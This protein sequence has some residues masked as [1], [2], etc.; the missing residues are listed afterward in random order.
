MK[1]RILSVFLVFL[2]VSMTPIFA[3]NAEMVQN[4]GNQNMGAE[5]DVEPDLVVASN[6][7]S[8]NEGFSNN[9]T[10]V[11]VNDTDT[12]YVDGSVG[13]DNNTGTKEKP[14]K[15]IKKALEVVKEN[16]K[17][18]IASGVYSEGSLKNSKSITLL[19]ENRDQ[20][21][22]SST[23]FNNF[24]KSVKIMDLKFTQGNMELGGAINNN[25]TLELENCLFEDNHASQGGA[26]Y[27]TGTITI[28]KC[29]FTGNGADK[30]DSSYG[31][32][33][34]NG[35]TGSCTITGSSFQNNQA[36]GDGGAI[37]NN[38]KAK[39]VVSDTQFSGNR[40]NSAGAIYSSLNCTLKNCNFENNIAD[41]IG[42]G[43]ISTGTLDIDDNIFT[44]NK[45]NE[46]EGG[47][48]FCSGTTTISNT[49][50]SKNHA[51]KGILTNYG[52]LSINGSQ[53]INNTAFYG[54]GIA[55]IRGSLSVFN[56]EF[57]GNKADNAGG[58]IVNYESSTADVGN[59]KFLNNYGY[60]GGAI[61]NAGPCTIKN[62][63]FTGNSASEAGAI[64]NA[65]QGTLTVVNAE[66]GNNSF[67]SNWAQND[68]GAICN[69]GHGIL[70]GNNFTYNEI[71]K[72]DGFGGAI[73]NT[74][75]LYLED[76]NYFFHNAINCIGGGIANL[77]LG[78][79]YINSTKFRSCSVFT[80][81]AIYN[82]AYLYI[83]NC[84][85][86]ENSNDGSAL[87]Q[88]K[89]SK[90]Y[91]CNENLN[92]LQFSSHWYRT[93]KIDL[94]F[95]VNGLT[96]FFPTHIDP[97]GNITVTQGQPVKVHTSYYRENWFYD[98]G[99]M[100][101]FFFDTPSM[102]DLRIRIYDAN[103][104]YYDVTFS[105]Y[106]DPYDIWLPE[107]DTSNMKPGKYVIQVTSDGNNWEHGAFTEGSACQ[108]GYLIIEPKT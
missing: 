51:I 90:E 24:G 79:L 52:S 89:D 49:T 88:G 103:Q 30:T 62:N 11:T 5:K 53:F 3:V 71:E 74:G 108:Y 46:Q 25:G 14:V 104:K 59:N 55:G 77:D 96:G 80:D 82:N 13:D 76:L 23:Q 28:T 27:N 86:E 50:F 102:S 12:I 72:N 31:G 61:H 42:G 43:L 2:M 10:N 95:W 34:F 7:V 41:K 91:K 97:I 21:I 106:W 44:G 8:G 67:T 66:I 35:K 45:A 65:F 18:R 85:I 38:Q 78:H 58:A 93:F 63:E 47:A 19:G 39:L 26:I 20:S 36:K 100:H 75:I 101:K 73:V 105:K 92:P 32:A 94:G 84:M 48:I 40:A 9:T 87:V 29:T 54:A 99:V 33:I 83:E 37:N 17:I 69:V 6:D 56:N 4:N 57:S 70:T 81:S 98:W 22:L 107:L 15:T 1:K 64:Y 60:Q 68:G 16:G